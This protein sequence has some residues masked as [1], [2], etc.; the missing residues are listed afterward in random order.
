MAAHAI[1]YAAPAAFLAGDEGGCTLGD[2]RFESGETLQDLRIGYT[3]HG[4]LNAARDNAILLFPGTANTR[5]SADGYIG[6]GQAFDTTRDFV[7]ATDAIGAGTSSQ[8]ADGLGGAFPR[9]N[10]RDMVRAQHALA[11]RAFGLTHLKAVAGASMGA[12]QALE[13]SILFPQMA[14]R[15]MLLVPA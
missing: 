11:T 10:I 3:T 9:Y 6:A 14:D 2:F 5:H 13:W 7:I 4:R 8:P 15:A 1:D 12:F